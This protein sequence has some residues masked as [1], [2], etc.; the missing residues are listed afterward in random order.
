M[1]KKLALFLAALSVLD[2]FADVQSEWYKDLT[3]KKELTCLVVGK[4]EIMISDVNGGDYRFKTSNAILS[5]TPFGWCLTLYGAEIGGRGI[6]ADG[7]LTIKLAEG[8]ANHI[9]ITSYTEQLSPGIGYYGDAAYGIKVYGNLLIHGVGSLTINNLCDRSGGP[10]IDG[11]DPAGINIG[12][13]GWYAGSL[14]VGLG[15]SLSIYTTG[16]DGIHADNGG[17]VNI[18][19]ACVELVGGCGIRTADNVKALGSV[20]TILSLSGSCIQCGNI[21]ADYM[22]GV[23]VSKSACAISCSENLVLDSSVICALTSKA[24]CIGAKNCSTWRATLYVG[25][26][27]LDRVNCIYSSL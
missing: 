21:E 10:L 26:V 24:A 7:D 20:I 4:E 25:T 1:N 23:F 16:Y 14:T 6:Q 11:C 3:K 22:F 12:L 2:L 19:G 9:S 27:Y 18:K 17:N 15:S 5:R 8:S 13:N